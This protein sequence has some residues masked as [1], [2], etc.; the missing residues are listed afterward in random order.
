MKTEKEI[1]KESKT[2]YTKVYL[3]KM[4]GGNFSISSRSIIGITPKII[5]PCIV[6]NS[7]LGSIKTQETTQTTENDNPADNFMR[8]PDKNATT[9]TTKKRYMPPQNF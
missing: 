9:R 1:I 3:I 7:S 6:K 8:S 5:S 2:K 4:V